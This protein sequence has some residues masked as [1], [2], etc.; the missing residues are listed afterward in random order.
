VY[1]LC[2]HTLS[3]GLC[4]DSAKPHTMPAAIFTGRDKAFLVAYLARCGNK[5]HSVN[6]MSA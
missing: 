4:K 2:G 1:V 3:A 5:I 6:K